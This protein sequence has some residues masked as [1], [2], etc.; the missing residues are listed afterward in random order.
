M[1]TIT[2]HT[3]ES[4]N[5]I[6]ISNRTFEDIIDI[7]ESNN[8]SGTIY[9]ITKFSSG[10]IKKLTIAKYNNGILLVFNKK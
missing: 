1:E 4:N 8:M 3:F 6:K 9:S 7:V 10:K 2:R 5:K